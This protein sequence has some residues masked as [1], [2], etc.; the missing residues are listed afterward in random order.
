M[1]KQKE[2]KITVPKFRVSFPQVFEAKVGP[3]GG[4][5]K[6]SITMLWLKGTDLTQLKRI[7]QE[8]I[9]AKFGAKVPSDLYVPL[10]DGDKKYNDNPELYS[11]YKGCVVATAKSIGKPG[12]I[13]PDM[14]KIIDP[15]ELYAGC[16]AH[17]TVTAYGWGPIVGKCGVSLGLQN[18]QKLNDGERISGKSDAEDD[19]E[20]ISA[21][22]NQTCL[23]TPEFS[24]VQLDF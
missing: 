7:I 8:A 17:A 20:P 4:K 16:Y 3:T 9:T 23:D 1:S 22:N 5:P 21:P 18:I 14:S 2:E 10:S 24:G 6:Y 13:Y 15:N 12:V 19:F 11:S